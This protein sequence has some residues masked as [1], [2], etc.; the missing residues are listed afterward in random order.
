MN[1]VDVFQRLFQHRAWVNANLLAAAAK[2][3]DE[4]LRAPFQIGQGSIWKSLVHMHA[5]EYVWL[6]SLLGN[7]QPLLPGDLPGTIP[8]NQQ[9]EGGIKDLQE[10]R[11]KWSVLEQRWTAYLAALKPEALEDRVYR[12]STSFGAGKRFATRRSDVMLHVC[13]HAHYT[14]AQ[15]V[16]MFR[17]SGADKLPD[18]MHIA[19]ARQEE[20][21]G[22]P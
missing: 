19:M 11:Q 5:A 16:N 13:M 9:G 22:R 10:L 17:Q 3:T 20:G 15:V 6:E 12:T 2:L 18:T 21:A 4:Q 8:G 1:A 14:A 7:E